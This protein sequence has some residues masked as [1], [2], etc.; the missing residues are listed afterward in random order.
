M[1]STLSP[2]RKPAVA[3]R[4]QNVE[5]YLEASLQPVRP[6]PAYV[7]GLRTRLVTAASQRDANRQ[8]FGYLM[9]TL[10]GVAGGTLFLATG[11]RAVF[12]LV[13]MIGLIRLARDS[14]NEQRRTSIAH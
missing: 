12:S 6:R 13:G 1:R 4:T 5:R 3:A 9:L 11:L 7:A 14:A 10:I 8:V 2:K